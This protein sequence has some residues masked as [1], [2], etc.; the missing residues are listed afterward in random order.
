MKRQLGRIGGGI[1]QAGYLIYLVLL[2]GYVAYLFADVILRDLLRGESFYLI[3]SVIMLLVLY[4]LAGGI[5]GRARAYEML[6]WFLLIPLFL[7]LFA[8][9]DEV[10]TDYWA[11]LGMSS[12]KG[13]AGGAYGVFL[14]LSFAFLLLFSGTYVRR[15]E[16]LFAAGKRAILFVGC[17]HAVLYL[18]LEGIFG[19]P[20]LAGMDYPAVTLMSTVKISGGFLKRTDAFMFGVWFFTL[21]ALLNSCVFYGSSIA[22][23]LWKPILKMP[24]GKKYMWI[25][26][27]SVAVAASAAAICFY[28]SRAVFDW[29]ERFLWYV[30]TP[31]LVLA[32]VFT[33]QKKWGRRML[34]LAVICAAALLVM[35]GCAPAE[36]EDRDF[37]I[38]IAVRDMKDAGLTWYEAEQEGNRMVD[39]S[40]LKVLILEQE[41]VEDEAAVQEWLTFLKEKSEVPRNAYVV[42]TEDAEALLA[43]SET[44]GEAV[45]DYLEEQF[46]NVSQIKKQAYPTIGSLYQEMDN[47]QETL[48]CRM[49]LWRRKSRRWSSIMCGSAGRRRAW[50][51]GRQRD[52]PF[53][54]KTA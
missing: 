31:F 15:Q 36:L 11:P 19:V 51:P 52:S 26:Y 33:A 23:K 17:L 1:V 53:S 27:G 49:L 48:F 34:A 5:E 21:Y 30:G 47:R 2:A 42:V 50:L 14:N 12:L 18:V 32:P 3:L 20:A 35:T 24:K 4:G 54:R 44:L 8:A 45:G 39:Y 29:Y 40:H 10:C 16:T 25:F 6:F 43:Q 28:R 13:V 22:E 38:D 37:P 7:M 46:E 9:A 41:F